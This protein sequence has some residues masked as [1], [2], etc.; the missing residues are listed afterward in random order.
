MIRLSVIIPTFKRGELLTQCLKSI[1]ESISKDDEIIV[2][3]DYPEVPVNSILAQK[4]INFRILD[5]PKKG[6]ASARN[7][8]AKHAKGKYL[9]FIDD[10]MIINKHAIEECYKTLIR[11]NKATI[12]SDWVYPSYLVNKI[13]KHQLGRYLIHINFTTLE[14]WCNDIE[15]KSNSLIKNNGI[16]SQFLMIEKSLFD[17]SNGYN[18]SFPFAGYEDYDFG[19]RLKSKDVDFFV[20]TNCQI[21][22]NELDKTNYIEY[23]SRKYR[24]GLTLKNAVD[25]GYTE[26]KM[27]HVTLFKVY[28]WFIA[29]M[30]KTFLF[31]IK[32]IPNNK[33]FDP[34]YRLILNRL[35]GLNIY[36]GYHSKKQ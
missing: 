18:E 33:S 31:L 3:N 17:E 11:K 26:L 8:G 35:V 28:Y 29:R 12:N 14:G 34:I 13:E 27:N 22:H 32:I 7:F 16:T 9:L 19:E 25:L 21:H 24:G 10:D 4:E 6:V 5:N 2:V 23:L 15:W 1:E 30:E 36:K 20:N